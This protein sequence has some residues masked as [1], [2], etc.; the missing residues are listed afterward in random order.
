MAELTEETIKNLAKLSRIHCTG[1][2]EAAL[3]NDLRKILQYMEQL[4]QIDTANVVPCYQVLEGL[5]NVI[6]EDEVTDFLSRETFLANAPDQI[7]GM[8]RVP[9]IIQ[10]E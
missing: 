7:G 10:Q 4:N 5:V 6:R 8:I 2:E 1:E 3:L 9:P